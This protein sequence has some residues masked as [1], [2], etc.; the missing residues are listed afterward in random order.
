MTSTRTAIDGAIEI[1]PAATHPDIGLNNIPATA[2]PTALS[3]ERLPQIEARAL[4]K[5]KKAME[6]RKIDNAL[7]H[8]HAMVDY[9]VSGQP[10]WWSE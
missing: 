3:R 6:A 7:Q 8:H 2:D 10:G 5:L 4:Q 9:H 1:P